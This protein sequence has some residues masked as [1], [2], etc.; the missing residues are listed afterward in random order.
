MEENIKRYLEDYV[1]ICYSR[2]EKGSSIH[3][4]AYEGLDLYNE[5]IQELADVSNYA[6]LEYVKVRELAEK[7]KRLLEKQKDSD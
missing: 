5:I 2:L 4:N 1:K 7:K 3:H 6:F